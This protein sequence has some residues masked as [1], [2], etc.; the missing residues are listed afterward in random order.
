MPHLPCLST[1]AYVIQEGSA[2]TTKSS[3]KI[4]AAAVLFKKPAQSKSSPNGQKFGQ[5]GHPGEHGQIDPNI[6]F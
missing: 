1:S 5:S 6:D 2:T 3:P 4:R